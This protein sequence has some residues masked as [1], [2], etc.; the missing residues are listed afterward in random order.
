M[1]Q[2]I[3]IA[4]TSDIPAGEGRSFEVQSISIGI[5][6]VQ[7]T[8]Y[9]LDNICA[10]SGGPLGEGVLDGNNIMCPWHAWEFDVTSGKCA[11]NSE[12]AQKKFPVK[13]EQDD[14]LI[15]I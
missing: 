12:I 9:A 7:G 10:H 11:G 14:I 4:K 1:G 8:F 2:W 6:N 15:E 5:F 3:K 13:V